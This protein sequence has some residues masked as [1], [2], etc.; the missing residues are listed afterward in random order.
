MLR[1]FFSSKMKSFVLF[2]FKCAIAKYSSLDIVAEPRRQL[3]CQVDSFSK[4][5][6]CF[7][8]FLLVLQVTE[9]KTQPVSHTLRFHGNQYDVETLKSSDTTIQKL[10]KKD[11]CSI[12]FSLRRCSSSL[13][14]L[15]LWKH[16]RFGSNDSPIK[17]SRLSNVLSRSTKSSL[18]F[19]RWKFSKLFSLKVAELQTLNPTADATELISAICGDAGWLQEVRSTQKTNAS[20]FVF[21]FFFSRSIVSRRLFNRPI[22]SFFPTSKS[23]GEKR[24][25]TH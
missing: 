23:P 21:S 17:T 19:V 5:E 18:K 25:S 15:R 24:S 22:I 8:R 16:R 13:G 6:L 10:V 3:H 1:Y 11:F 20:S 7:W 9:D 4:T 2:C 12:F 14:T